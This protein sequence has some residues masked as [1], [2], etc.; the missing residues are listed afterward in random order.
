MQVY[1]GLLHLVHELLKQQLADLKDDAF[2]IPDPPKLWSETYF[3]NDCDDIFDDDVLPYRHKKLSKLGLDLSTIV[4]VDDNP[5]SFRGYEPNAI[6][7]AGFWGQSHPVDNEV[8][9]IVFYFNNFIS[10]K[11]K[12]NTTSWKTTWWSHI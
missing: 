11:T 6:R 12:Q 7:V 9:P 8:Q 10:H 5:L 1:K 2:T 4:I 3:R